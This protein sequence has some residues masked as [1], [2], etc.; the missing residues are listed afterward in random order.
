MDD[1]PG[2]EL[3]GVF[4]D[5]EEGGDVFGQPDEKADQ[6]EGEEQRHFSVPVIG[7]KD[8]RCAGIEADGAGGDVPAVIADEVMGEEVGVDGDADQGRHPVGGI[9]ANAHIQQPPRLNDVAADGGIHEAGK[10]GTPSTL[11]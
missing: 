7:T 2:A 9:V 5:A 3:I 8:H 1:G 11:V 10:S 6:D 4:P